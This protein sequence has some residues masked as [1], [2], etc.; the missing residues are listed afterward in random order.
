MTMLSSQIKVNA[1][2]WAWVYLEGLH[3]HETLDEGDGDH[4][5]EDQAEREPRNEEAADEQLRKGSK[6]REMRMQFRVS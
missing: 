6:M 1:M 2:V 4:V 3:V 5:E